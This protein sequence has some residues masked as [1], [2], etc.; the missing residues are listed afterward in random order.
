M[1]DYK[2]IHQNVR[3]KTNYKAV[4]AVF[5]INL[6]KP[7]YF[8]FIFRNPEFFF[9][10]SYVNKGILI[11]G[12]LK[13]E[14][15]SNTQANAKGWKLFLF[16]H[17]NAFEENGYQLKY[18]HRFFV[19]QSFFDTR[20]TEFHCSSKK[21]P[22]ILLKGS[23]NKKIFRIFLKWNAFNFSFVKSADFYV[24]ISFE[25]KYKLQ[26]CLCSSYTLP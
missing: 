26:L 2:T 6:W 19:F 3:W 11:V 8:H 14:H 15:I 9:Y 7:I 10:Q 5:K 25:K 1:V 16:W 4:A 24:I 13:S 12:L 23:E 17:S 18:V 20:S 22:N 21:F